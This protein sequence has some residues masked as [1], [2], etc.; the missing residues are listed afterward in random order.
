VLLSCL[1]FVDCSR[2]RESHML[3]ALRDVH[4]TAYLGPAQSKGLSP[5]LVAQRS[6][7]YY[8]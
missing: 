1:T 6:R 7:A 2:C 4:R 8:H 3:H 5:E